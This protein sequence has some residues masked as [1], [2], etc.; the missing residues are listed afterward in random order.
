LRSCATNALLP[1]APEAHVVCR[2]RRNGCH[3]A[4]RG[5]QWASIQACPSQ[6]SPSEPP[7]AQASSADVDATATSLPGT[8]GVGTSRH[9]AMHPPAARPACTLRPPRT[10]PRRELPGV[11]PQRAARPSSSHGRGPVRDERLPR[12]RATTRRAPT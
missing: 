5:R 3:T 2:D 8:G 4:E 11:L 6:C 10:P 12:P 9:A 7:T 1:V